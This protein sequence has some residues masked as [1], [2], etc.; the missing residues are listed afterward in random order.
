MHGYTPP[1]TTDRLIA[2]VLAKPR[3]ERTN[4]LH[5]AIM[6]APTLEICEALLRGEDVPRSQLDPDW[7]TR[8]GV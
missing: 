5:R 1:D 6:L 8:Y 4:R 7:A 2:L 3:R